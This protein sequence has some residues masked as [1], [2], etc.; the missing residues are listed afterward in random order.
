MIKI[1]APAFALLMSG[2]AAAQNGSDQDQS[3]TLVGNLV[4]DCVVDFDPNAGVDYF[5][6]KY[7]KPI[8][9]SYGDRD[10]FGEKFVPHNTTDFLD[11]EY[12]NTYKIV[13]N[14]HQDPPKKYLLYQCGTQIPEDVDVDS[15]DLVTSV[16][17]KGGLALT[18]TPQ[19]PYVELLGLRE[20]IVAYIGDPF[21]VTS[22]C[23]THMMEGET[24]MIE[25]VHNYSIQEELIDDFR[26]RN[27]DAIIVSGPSNNVVGEQ[28]I[29]SSATQER[30]NVATFDWI[31]FFAAFYN[32]EGEA[33][34]ITSNMQESYDCSSDVASFMAAEQRELEAEEGPTIMW[35]NY[36]TYQNLG[37]SVGEC[38]TWDHAYYCEY[39]TH[40]G[41]T[42]LTRPEG[43]GV[44]KT[45]GSPTVYWYLND[46]EMLD[47]GMDAD[48]LIYSGSDWNEIY[49][50]KNET[51][52]KM[53]AV[54]NGQ[55]YDVLGQGS[56]AWYEQRYAEYDVVGLDM[57]N[58]VGYAPASG[59]QNR[60]FRNVF[61]DPIGEL[62]EC[63]VLG[64]EIS[65]PYVP[66]QQECVRPLIA[67][68]D[69]AGSEDTL[70]PEPSASA[71]A[72]S[73]DA[74][75]PEPAAPTSDEPFAT[76]PATTGLESAATRPVTI[77]TATI[78]AAVV[79]FL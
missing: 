48:I 28:V 21:Y 4:D 18:E 27:P 43:V 47:M 6:N 32:M 20:S 13:T 39:A 58:I 16:P 63:D 60:W 35:A 40:C 34:R 19:I 56:S 29:V 52:N 30:T 5:P 41:A 62:E 64:G 49:A 75:M 46:E 45:W 69:D 67:P 65:E 77:G 2:F 59:H 10:I 55:V 3:A 8:I 33:N 71:D 38:P 42:V 25:T 61:T 31:S 12:F 73:E 37:W 74:P 68:S 72:G 22:P 24:P 44:N 50:L 36:L 17:H 26:E 14:L 78:L 23:M 70:M 57:C 54:Q 7:S 51:L 11:I 1:A 53:K 15:F 79:F 76:V 9:K 66:P